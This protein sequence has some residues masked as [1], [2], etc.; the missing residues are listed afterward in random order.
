MRTIISSVAVSVLL[1]F[2]TVVAAQRTPSCEEWNT[3]EYF[4]TATVENVT[5]CLDAGA[6]PMARDKWDTTPLQNAWYNENPAV[7]QA[8]IDA[9]ADPKVRD[10]RGRTPLH[11]AAYNKNSAVIEVLLAA[12][13]DLE[14]KDEDGRTPLHL[15]ALNK[16]SAMV[17]VLLAAGAKVNARDKGGATVLRSAVWG[18]AAVVEVL[19]AGR[20]QSQC[21]CTERMGRHD[22]ACCGSDQESGGDPGPARGRCQSQC[23]GQMGPHAFT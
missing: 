13:A 18:S 20:R 3:K 10:E 9:G 14:A 21:Q 11:W 19:L 15:A 17:Q 22:P 4:Q 6:D 16:N 7:I 2:L 12:G 5:A 8:L 23:A 1:G